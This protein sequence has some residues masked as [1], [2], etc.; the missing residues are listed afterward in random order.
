MAG[1]GEERAFDPDLSYDWGGSRSKKGEGYGWGRKKQKSATLVLRLL[2][3]AL[4]ASDW[5]VLLT[6]TGFSRY[7]LLW[8]PLVLFLFSGNVYE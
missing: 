1:E 7:G 6:T 5:R 2:V 8:F 4:D 3:I